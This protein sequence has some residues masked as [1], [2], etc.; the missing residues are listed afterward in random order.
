MSDK[1]S[2]KVIYETIRKVARI[3]LNNGELNL[4]DKEQVVGFR[5]ALL[6]VKNDTKIRAL[7][8]QANGRAFSA[9]FNL[10]Q[11]TNE[12]ST[13]QIFRDVGKEFIRLLNHMTIPTIC[14][15]HNYAIGIACLVP[16][17]CD[18]RFVL[19]DVAFCLPEINYSFMFPTHGG[20]TITPKICRSDSDAKYILMTGEHIKLELA[21]KMG[22][23]TKI[24]E[25]KEEMEKE[26]L[27]F[28]T[29]L[30]KKNPPTMSM[31]KACFDKC[32]ASTL[33]EGMIIEAEAEEINT[34]NK[35]E[36]EVG[37]KKFIEKYQLK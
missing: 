16:F 33:E 1:S 21:D 32:K 8:I 18:F 30:S 19:K 36:R 22:L 29:T 6:K 9:G 34:S 20:M 5:D 26:G 25:T 27:E 28:A 11:M 14:L 3:T 7:L 17:A 37:I 12:K 4:F 35:A 10:K 15:V 31:I 24:F 23:V 2:E 13:L